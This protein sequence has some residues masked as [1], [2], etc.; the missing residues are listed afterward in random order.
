ML[1][2]HETGSDAVGALAS[3]SPVNILEL[4]LAQGADELSQSYLLKKMEVNFTFRV[5][6]DT[7]ISALDTTRVGALV[8]AKLS[9]STDFDTVVEMLD[10]GIENAEAHRNLIWM[11]SFV[12]TPDL[13]D[14][15]ENVV[16]RGNHFEWNFSKSFPKGY[17]LDKDEHYQ[18]QIINLGTNAFQTGSFSSLRV[19]YWV[20]PL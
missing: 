9:Q 5:F 6:A 7:L 13:V 14:D 3:R 4:G 15:T 17:P 16:E 1:L 19:R 8:F 20:V 11:R 2:E 10:A 18:W 12:I